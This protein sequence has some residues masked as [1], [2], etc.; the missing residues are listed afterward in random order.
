[1]TFLTSFAPGITSHRKPVALSNLSGDKL[2]ILKIF[3]VG[4]SPFRGN[5]AIV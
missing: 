5:L 3:I 2:P 1:M 4:L